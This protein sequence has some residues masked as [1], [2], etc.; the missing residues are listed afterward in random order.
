MSDGFDVAASL[1]EWRQNWPADAGIVTGGPG[2]QVLFE[3]PYVRV[4]QLE[5]QP[6]ES[7]T[8]HCHVHPYLYVVL[9]PSTILVKYA[10]GTEGRTQQEEG[11]TVWAGLD[12]ATRTH[13]L[14]NVGG[15]PCVERVIEIL[16]PPQGA[17]GATRS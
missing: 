4:W 6:G 16:L 2:D 9:R 7:T 17:P 12:D 3:N 15:Q 14:I 13:A 5:L 1:L 10:D 8:L 11:A